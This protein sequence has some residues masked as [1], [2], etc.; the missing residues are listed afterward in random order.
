[1]LAMFPAL[2]SESVMDFMDGLPAATPISF[3]GGEDIRTTAV[4]KSDEQ[5]TCTVQPMEGMTVA[6]AFAA[7]SSSPAR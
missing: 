6:N 1:M 7:D 3:G 2:K 4:L 5:S